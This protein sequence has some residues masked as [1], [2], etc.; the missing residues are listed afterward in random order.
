[1]QAESLEDILKSLRLFGYSENRLGQPDILNQDPLPYYSSSVRVYLNET[2]LLT[3]MTGS[4]LILF[5]NMELDFIDHVEIYQGFPSFDFGIEPA[6]IVIRLYTKTAQH[7]E[8]GR[9][10]VNLS[11]N[12]ANKENVYYTNVEDGVSYFIY[13]NRADNKKDTYKQNLAP[14]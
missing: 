14:V 9:V 11:T 3:S 2:E 10:K 8:G 12:G 13:A 5:G 4:G 7:D 1:M 6:T